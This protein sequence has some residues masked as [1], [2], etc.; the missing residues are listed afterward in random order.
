MNLA[1]LI[2]LGADRD[3]LERELSKLNVHG[4]WKLECRQCCAGRHPRHAG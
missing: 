1:A 4:E 2:D 3:I